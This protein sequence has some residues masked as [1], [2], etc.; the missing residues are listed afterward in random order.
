M[1]HAYIFL[2]FQIL[3]L[4]RIDAEVLRF[5]GYVDSRLYIHNDKADSHRDSRDYFTMDIGNDCSYIV[6]LVNPVL[7]NDYCEVAYDGKNSYYLNN[8]SSLVH[9]TRS[10]GNVATAIIRTSEVPQFFFADAAGPLWLAYAS[11]CFFARIKPGDLVPPAACNG[12]W[13]GNALTPDMF[14]EFQSYFEK[15]GDGAVESVVY[16]HPGQNMIANTALPPPYN[17]GFTNV[18]FRVEKWAPFGLDGEFPKNST[19]DVFYLSFRRS[20]HPQIQRR[21][22]SHGRL[23]ERNFGKP[24]YFQTRHSG[25]YFS[26]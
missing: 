5:Y 8:M 18:V 11:K 23:H 22:M 3:G 16:R 14:V 1:R 10:N 7:G 19:M 17:N 9:R 6:R 15:R 21:I 4:L 20:D 25:Y 12:I 24:R 26:R 2:I 13:Y